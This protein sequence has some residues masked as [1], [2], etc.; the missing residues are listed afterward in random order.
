[1]RIYLAG[2]MTGYPMFNF[3]LFDKQRDFLKGLGHDVISPADLDR[4]AGFNPI[5][6]CA[7]ADFMTKAIL[8]DLTAITTVEALALLPGWDKSRGVKVELAL[9]GF[10]QLDI[11]DAMTGSAIEPEGIL[12][13]AQRLTDKDRNKTYGEPIEDFSR[14]GLLWSAILGTEVTAEKAQLC[15]IALKLSRL[16]KT[17]DHEDSVVDVAGYAQTYSRTIRARKKGWP[18]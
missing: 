2:P 10:L 8:R 15:M 3:P 14:T 5:F 7:D 4:E 16:C 13:T 11:L 9:A 18:K 1:M 12:V 6:D 17:P